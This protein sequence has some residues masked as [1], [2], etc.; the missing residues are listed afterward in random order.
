MTG[1]LK[2]ET[3][4]FVTNALF[5]HKPAKQVALSV[6]RDE[7]LDAEAVIVVVCIG[8][9]EFIDLASAEN[10]SMSIGPAPTAGA[11]EFDTPN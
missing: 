3:H 11:F 8:A 4:D 7:G 6:Y 2:V 1:L 5:V 9:L 10:P